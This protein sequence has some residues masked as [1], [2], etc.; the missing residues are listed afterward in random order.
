MPLVLTIDYMALSYSAVAVECCDWATDQQ[1]IE[2]RLHSRHLI[3]DVLPQQG[4]VAQLL[5]LNVLDNPLSMG[6]P[7]QRI[8]AHP[9]RRQIML[10]PEPINEVYLPATTAAGSQ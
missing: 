5:W 1:L 10:P 2:P 9:T 3:S 8:Q 4:T 6:L 7:K